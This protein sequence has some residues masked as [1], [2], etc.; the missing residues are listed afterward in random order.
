[1]DEEEIQ[2]ILDNFKDAGAVERNK[3]GYRLTEQG[4]EIAETMI[5][6]R[7]DMQL[8]LF[9]I[10]WN[11]MPNYTN[12]HRKLIKI[13]KDLKENPGINIFRTIESNPDKLDG[14]ELTVDQL[15]EDFVQQFDPK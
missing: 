11:Q 2:D 1:M 5:G 10:R 15:P 8:K 7:P 3:Q 6:T 13:A 9:A 12:P 14:I 4:A